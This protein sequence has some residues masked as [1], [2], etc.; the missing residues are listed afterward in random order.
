MR[1]GRCSDR[2][3]SVI[4][5]VMGIGDDRDEMV[6][7]PRLSPYHMTWRVRK[8]GIPPMIGKEMEFQPRFHPYRLK[9]NGRKKGKEEKR[10]GKRNLSLFLRILIGNCQLIEHQ[11]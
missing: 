5:G 3:S 11:S 9:T 7:I 4:Y 1:A 8:A 10:I 6:L 2:P